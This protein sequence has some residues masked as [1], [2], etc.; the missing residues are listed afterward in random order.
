MTRR[1]LWVETTEVNVQAASFASLMTSIDA[2]NPRHSSYGS[3]NVRTRS[4][5]HRQPVPLL[6]QSHLKGRRGKGH[7]LD[8]GAFVGGL[9]AELLGLRRVPKAFQEFAV[10]SFTGVD[11]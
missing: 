3:W 9:G 5:R 8:E 1:M 10:Y 6:D 11:P 2:V 4:S 7:R